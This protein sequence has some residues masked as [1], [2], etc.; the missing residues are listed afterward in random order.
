MQQLSGINVLVYYAPHTF[1]TDLGMNYITSLQIGAGLSVTYW[2]FSFSQAC[3]LDQMGRRR[4][5]I[6][7][8]VLQAICFLCVSFPAPLLTR[9]K[10]LNSKL[11]TGGSPPERHQPSTRQ[12]LD[13]LLLRL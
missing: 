13:I 3:F 12:S 9:P 2:V 7:G 5:L 10:D 4:P 11:P 1:T 8:A 6:V